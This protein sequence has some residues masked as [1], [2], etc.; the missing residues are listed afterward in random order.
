MATNYRQVCVRLSIWIDHRR[1][2]DRG[3]SLTEYAMLVALIAV[4]CLA[5]IEYMGDVAA[6]KFSRVGASI[7]QP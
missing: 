6:E 4:T 5:S 3:A 7:G 1:R 2:E